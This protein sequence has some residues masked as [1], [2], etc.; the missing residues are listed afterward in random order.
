MSSIYVKS[1]LFIFLFFI[2]N[3][4]FWSRDVSCEAPRVMPHCTS[5][6]SLRWCGWCHHRLVG[7]VET[8]CT[9]L[10]SSEATEAL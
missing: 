4:P 10:Y 9:H 8:L 6:W 3:S 1:S 2:F 5:G 7:I